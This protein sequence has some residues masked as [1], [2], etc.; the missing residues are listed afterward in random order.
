M[1]LSL[2][3]GENN[4]QSHLLFG[5]QL[6]AGTQFAKACRFVQQNRFAVFSDIL[7]SLAVG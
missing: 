3:F 2:D 7:L 1:L 6:L 5:T 4:T